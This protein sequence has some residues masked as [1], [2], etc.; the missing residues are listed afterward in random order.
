MSVFDDF[1][2]LG[3]TE[4]RCGD[5]DC[6]RGRIGGW[7]YQFKDGP[8]NAPGCQ[9]PAGL[10][11]RHHFTDTPATP[12]VDAGK[13]ALAAWRR[14]EAVLHIKVTPKMLAEMFH[15]GEHGEALHTGLRRDCAR[16]RF[17]A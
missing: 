1:N 12:I 5:R 7:N 16:C 3:C 6:Y 8:C 14:I 13:E 10:T 9:W 2:A 11:A 15:I 17:R 4:P